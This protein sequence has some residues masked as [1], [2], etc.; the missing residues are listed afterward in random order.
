MRVTMTAEREDTVE[1][2]ILENFN[3]TRFHKFNVDC[4]SEGTKVCQYYYFS[5]SNIL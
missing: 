5:H 1:T 4:K 3:H 2:D